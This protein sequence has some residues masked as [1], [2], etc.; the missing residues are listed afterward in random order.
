ML[1]MEQ[2]R[3]VPINLATYRTL[4]RFIRLRITIESRHY[5]GPTARIAHNIEVVQGGLTFEFNNAGLVAGVR[6]TYLD[7]TTTLRGLDI[8]IVQLRFRE[9]NFILFILNP[10][11]SRAVP[12]ATGRVFNADILDPA[13]A[14]VMSLDEIVID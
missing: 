11:R 9:M 1:R 3:L 2:R 4:L 13:N 12:L 10:D 7:V 14:T 8:G 6:P 5:G